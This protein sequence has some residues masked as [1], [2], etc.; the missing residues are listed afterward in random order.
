MSSFANFFKLKP[1]VWALIICLLLLPFISWLYIRKGVDF[2]LNALEEL[3]N[4]VE[5]PA[6]STYLNENKPFSNDS[7]AGRVSIFF[8]VANVG[9]TAHLKTILRQVY[10]QNEGSIAVRIYL[11]GDSGLAG[12]LNLDSVLVMRHFVQFAPDSIFDQLHHTFR[13]K[14]IVAIEN[15]NVLIVDNQ[16]NIRYVY[17]VSDPN[18]VKKL[19]QHSGVLI[20]AYKKQ[21]PELIRQDA[22]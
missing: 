12:Q 19:I 5:A 11:C 20:P 4:K 2:R 15:P 21:K 3:K 7:L 18:D 16:R 22:F 6:F 10:D 14:T 8:D 13:T 17:D 9:N 1:G